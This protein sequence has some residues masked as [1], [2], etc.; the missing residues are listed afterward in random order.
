MSFFFPEL[1]TICFGLIIAFVLIALMDA[2]FGAGR[3]GLVIERKLPSRFAL[4]VETEVTIVLRNVGKR[5][6]VFEVFDGLPTS[7]EVTD[8]PW[9]GVVDPGRNLSFTYPV[10]MMSRGEFQFDAAYIRR[11]SPL[12]LWNKIFRLGDTQN[13]R[14]YPN[15][16]P[17]IRFALLA[18]DNRETQMGI[19]HRN[20][21]GQSR[22]FHQLR[23][24]HEGDSLSQIDWKATSKMLKLISR[25]YRE[26][27]NQNL[28]I[29]IDSGRRMRALDGGIPQFDHTLNAALLLGYTALRQGDQ[30][31]VLGFGDGN[32]W[33]PPLKGAS[34]MTPILNHLY[35]FQTSLQPTDYAE[36]AE[37]LMAHQR[38]RSLVILLTNLRSEDASEIIPSLRMLRK[39]HLVVVGSLLEESLDSAVRQPVSNLN[40]ALLYGSA[41]LYYEERAAVVENLHAHNI[42]TIDDT[43]KR[44]PISL[45]NKYL[46]I[47]SAGM[48]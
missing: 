28:V 9:R 23:D 48:L 2:I 35:D 5:K 22:E 36:A 34:A 12:G 43:A 8:M 47:K 3:K 4:G 42:F 16:E 27:R 11:S 1:L 24:Y 7:C 40:E 31:G 33:L 14:V 6:A 38:R 10:K 37:F 17:V 30:V 46:E 29:M 19:Q 20:R 41:Q 26:Q 32:K 21:V 13:V 18:M 44:F 39:R 15:Y 45:A 25:E